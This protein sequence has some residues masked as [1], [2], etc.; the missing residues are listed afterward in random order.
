MI[1]PNATNNIVKAI[2][3]ELINIK[4]EHG[5]YYH[6]TH[7]GFAI[8]LEEVQE[9]DEE[10]KRI[11]TD[12]RILWER[13]K[14]NFDSLENT[15]NASNLLMIVMNAKN[16]AEEAVQVAAVAEKFA[17]TIDDKGVK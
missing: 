2:H 9:V 1:A 7:E 12:M 5:E 16:L 10:L 3:E 8:L 4:A 13:I 15:D 6:S 14:N 11:K 17:K